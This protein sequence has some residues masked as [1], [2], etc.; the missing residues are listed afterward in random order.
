M[1]D[2]KV[3]QVMVIMPTSVPRIDNFA[4]ISSIRKKITT[5]I[6]SI[7]PR[8]NIEDLSGWRLLLHIDSVC[9]DYISV[10]KK[11]WRILRIENT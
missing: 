7:L 3:K 11:F 2:K 8:I 4:E 6:D 5:Y 9:S 1:K 10:Y